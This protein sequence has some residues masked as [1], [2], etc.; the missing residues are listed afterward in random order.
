MTSRE[1]DVL[2]LVAEGMSN[3]EVGRRLF[4]SPRTV[5]THV[6]SLLA[7]TGAT[8]RAGLRAIAC[9]GPQRPA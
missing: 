2:G 7:K 4:V 6:A 8:N 9:S 5:E 1:M 3:A